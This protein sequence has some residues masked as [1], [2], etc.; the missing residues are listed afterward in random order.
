[1]IAGLNFCRGLYEYF[2]GQPNAALLAFNR[3]RG[4][5]I[6]G[7]RAIRFML[8]ICLSGENEALENVTD[9]DSQ[10]EVQ[11]TELMALHTAAKLLQE[12]RPLEDDPLQTHALYP[13]FYLLATRQKSNVERAL[14]ELT[15]S[16]NQSTA[17]ENPGAILGMATA[18][19]VSNVTSSL[20]Q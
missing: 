9:M 13:S 16:A 17:R 5:P 1:M 12:L 14:Q 4:H 10:Y 2:G 7:Q 6:W 19:L 18:H 20:F 11:D 3:A 15:T 8:D